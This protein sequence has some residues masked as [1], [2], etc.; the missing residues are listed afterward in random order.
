MSKKITIFTDGAAKGNP[1]PG[2]YGVVLQT[3][4]HR[5]E[6]SEGYKLTTNN[7]MELL[8][9]IKGLEALKFRGSDVIVFTDSRYVVDAV[10]KEWVFEWERK[11]FRKKKNSDLWKRFLKIYRLHNVTFRWVEG[12]A[13]IEGNERCDRLAVEASEK[14]KLLEDEGYLEDKAGG[15]LFETE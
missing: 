3:D 1:G 10:N 6:L 11:A 9:V 2:G 12:H 14:D 5:K 7:R 13:G 4:R 15:K 8:A